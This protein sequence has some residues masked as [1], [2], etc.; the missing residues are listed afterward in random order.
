MNKTIIA[1]FIPI[2]AI[3]LL[4]SQPKQVVYHS[5]CVLGKMAMLAI[6]LF[7]TMLD[8]TL[9]AVVL[10]LAIIYYQS[11]FFEKLLNKDAMD[12]PMSERISYR[13]GNLEPMDNLEP[14][15]Q[16][17]V[18][19]TNPS[20]SLFDQWSATLSNAYNKVAPPLKD[21]TTVLLND[22]R[23]EYCDAG[24]LK[25]KGMDVN[26]E[27]TEHVF[28]EIQFKQEKCNPCSES[29]TFSIIESRLKTEAAMAAKSSRSN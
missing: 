16:S 26:A 11:D 13:L 28:P 3:F 12:Q 22:F 5:H 29:C 9:G 17:N 19:D 25:Y 20:N 14:S 10:V 23:Q 18:E 1:Q 21:H 24:K 4:L 2:I 15:M 6:V 27:M 8:K 7:Y